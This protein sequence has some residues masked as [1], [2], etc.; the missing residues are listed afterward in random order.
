[1]HKVL[2]LIDQSNVTDAV[3]ESLLLTLNLFHTFFYFSIVDF[4][5]VNVCWM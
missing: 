1:M 3:Q 4:Q 2:T 5:P